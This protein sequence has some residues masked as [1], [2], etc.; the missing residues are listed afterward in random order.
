MGVQINRK[1]PAPQSEATKGADRQKLLGPR[2][3][4]QQQRRARAPPGRHRA[5]LKNILEIM[6]MPGGVLQALPATAC[7]QQ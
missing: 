7:P 4:T 1:R 6:M 5:A 3:P 2:L